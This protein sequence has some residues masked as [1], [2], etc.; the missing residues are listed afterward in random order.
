MGNPNHDARGRFA[1]GSAS[2]AASGDHQSV[3]PHPDMR[4]VSGRAIPRSQVTTRHNNADSVT[5]DPPRRLGRAAAER[6]ALNQQL[7]QRAYPTRSDA[8]VAGMTDLS[9]VRPIAKGKLDP[10][11]STLVSARGPKP[12][13]RVTA[14]QQINARMNASARAAPR[15]QPTAG[16]LIGAGIIKGS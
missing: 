6:V 15:V 9:G 10:R 13:V 16:Q 4:N 12:R 11:T 8:D 1:S 14:T 5:S 2:G 7:D 3:S